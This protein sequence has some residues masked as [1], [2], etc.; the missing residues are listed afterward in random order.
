MEYPRWST[1]Y[2]S[3]RLATNISWALSQLPTNHQQ[4]LMMPRVRAPRIRSWVSVCHV[5]IV[6]S[7]DLIRMSCMWE[8]MRIFVFLMLLHVS[9]LMGK[10]VSYTPP[11]YKYHWLSWTNPCAMWT[12]PFGIWT[13]T[14]PL[15]SVSTKPKSLCGNSIDTATCVYI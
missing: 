9:G 2:Y 5:S 3:W 11:Y 12:D 10:I 6:L 15:V 14:L 4:I 13:Q 7:A 1:I 8:H